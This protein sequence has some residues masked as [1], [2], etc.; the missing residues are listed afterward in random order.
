MEPTRENAARQNNVAAPQVSTQQNTSD[1]TTN[2]NRKPRKPVTWTAPPSKPNDASKPYESLGAGVRGTP[3]SN[4]GNSVSQQAAHRPAFD[5]ASRALPP[6]RPSWAHRGHGGANLPI[7]SGL[8]GRGVQH[9]PL[10]IE[11][12]QF[13]NKR[14]PQVQRQ[15]G[16]EMGSTLGQLKSGG[17]PKGVAQPA[18]R[19]NHAAHPFVPRPPLQPPHQPHRPPQSQQQQRPPQQIRSG[20]PQQ[21]PAFPREQVPGAVSYADPRSNSRPV[22]QASTW[23]RGISDH[24]GECRG[25]ALCS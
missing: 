9:A 5:S 14:P 19:M 22:A 18:T 2:Q 24:V 11:R 8:R 16:D 15:H 21:Q 12:G 17:V 6:M 23:I 20:P 13:M 10:P 1:A 25:L 3:Q 7:V 4:R